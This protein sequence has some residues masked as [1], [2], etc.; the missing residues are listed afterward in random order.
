MALHEQGKID[1]DQFKK[2]VEFEQLQGR[3]QP[4]QSPA[5]CKVPDQQASFA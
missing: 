3:R 5:K 4:D 1:R 2:L